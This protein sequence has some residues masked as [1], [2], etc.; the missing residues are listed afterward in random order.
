M[1]LN[2]SNLVEEKNF[3]FLE[4][5][6]G[7]EGLAVRLSTSLERG[8]SNEKE[9]ILKQKSLYGNNTFPEKASVSYIQFVLKSLKDKTLIVLLI[10]SA[11]EIAIGIY[12]IASPFARGIEL[13][14]G[15]AILA[16]VT[17]VVNIGAIADY[18][19]QSQFKTL[20][21]IGESLNTINIVR[22][23]Q[24][25][26]VAK[27]DIVVGDVVQI[28]TGMV[29]PADGI[30]FSCYSISAD[31]S[32]MT[33]ESAGVTKDICQDPFVISGTLI[34]RG[35]GK[36][37]VIAT[38]LNSM[39]GK[40][41]LALDEKVE[42]TP[43]QAK[44]GLFAEMI[45]K[46]AFYLAIGMIVVLIAIYFI[47]NPGSNDVTKLATELLSFLILVI[48]IVVVVVP[49]GLPLAVNLSLAN[50]TVQMLKDNNLVRHFS[51]C[52][53]MGN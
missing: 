6:G 33:G 13:V 16:V 38:G 29:V 50:A 25:L 34:I 15:L 48:T 39:N 40:L 26:R 9:A 31:E 49:E 18:K 41:L 7:I 14:N 42:V 27:E 45:A 46:V 10:A 21:K 12:Q 43:L 4:E 24:L 47:V 36:M 1:T 17:I 8:F 52:E 28:E 53:T 51:A 22:N 2:L 23:G 5:I 3:A 32:S 30:L 44:L 35:V 20:K 19:K 37:L 11:I